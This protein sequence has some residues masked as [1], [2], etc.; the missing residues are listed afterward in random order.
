MESEDLNRVKFSA[1]GPLVL[2]RKLEGPVNEASNTEH[3]TEA[4]K[5]S[6]TVPITKVR[7]AASAPNIVGK[8][9]RKTL[10]KNGKRPH[11]RRKE[12]RKTY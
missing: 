3:T 9:V 4:S 2:D 1:A 5:V 7:K 8:R 10:S 11:A 12:S 6:Q